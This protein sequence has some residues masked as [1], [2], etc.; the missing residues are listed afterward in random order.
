VEAADGLEGVKLARNHCPPDL[1]LCDVNMGDVDGYT[2]ISVLRL[3][4]ATASIPL[5]LITGD[6]TFAGMRRSM[7][8]GA[9]DYLAK[10]FEVSDLISAIKMRLQKRK[11]LVDQSEKKLSDLRSN[12]SM[13][14]PRELFTP[15]TAIIGTAD[16]LVAESDKLKG[17]RIAELGNSLRESGQR[18][19]RLVNNFL[20][21]AQIELVSHHSAKIEPGSNE[22]S[23]N[24]AEIVESVAKS[25]AAERHRERDLL[26]ELKP[27][28]AA[29]AKH[30]LAKII[31]E[32]VDNAFKFSDPGTPVR[33]STNVW[34]GSVC[35]TV[36]D[37]GSGIKAGRI[38]EL[39]AFIQLERRLHAQEG[40]G[41]GLA[42]ARRLAELHGGH[43]IIESEAGIGTAVKMD[44]PK[45]G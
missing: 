38:P 7:A 43:L 13:M 45:P 27:G 17:E 42:I 21:Y 30:Y 9:D 28:N 10:P 1:I 33:V 24:V 8:L 3:N 15:L 29:I 35:L 14:L 32:I 23:L 19:N 36:I 16:Q 5:V 18:L 31:H 2:A 41:L 39:G 25:L 11:L 6:A 26:L 4:P 37:S 44:L 20:I 12:I 34:D 40:V 22:A